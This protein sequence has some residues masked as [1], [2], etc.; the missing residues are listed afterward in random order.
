MQVEQAE[1]TE[2]NKL[3]LALVAP[4]RHKDRYIGDWMEWDK[5]FELPIEKLLYFEPL[6]AEFHGAGLDG[7][8]KA[9]ERG[10]KIADTLK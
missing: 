1:L 6:N 8:M 10:L 2:D 5:C 3:R 7:Y 9:V 4:V